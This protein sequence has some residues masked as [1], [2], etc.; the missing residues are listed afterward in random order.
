MATSTIHVNLI[1]NSGESDVLN[2]CDKRR[3]LKK[4]KNDTEGA[5]Q[6]KA[7]NQE[8]KKS[9]K[10]AKE[11]WIKEQC[12]DINDS[13]ETNNSKKAYHL[14]KDLTSTK[15]GRTTTI[16]DKDK[17][18]LTK[19]QDILKRLKSQAEK[20]IAE[21]QAGFRQGRS[22]TEQIFNLKILCERY[23]QHQQD[24]YLV[25]VDFKKAFDRCRILQ[26][27]HW[28]LVQNH[29]WSETR[30]LLSPTLFNI[31]L[32]RI[33]TEALEDSEGTI[34]AE[35]TKLMTNNTNGSSTDIKV[36]GEKV[37]TVKSF[38]YLG[39]IVIDAGSKSEIFTRIAQTT[40]A[41]TK[42]KTILK[43]RNIALSSKIRL[44]R[45]LVMFRFL[46]A[47][48]AK[49]VLQGTVKGGRRRGR[50]RKRWEENVSEW[51]G[52]RLS[53]AFRQSERRDEWRELVARS[54]V[55]PNRSSRLRDK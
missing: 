16:P 43:D 38:K 3:D 48:L 10:K 50:K 15:Q 55:V 9:M 42:L 45:A 36:C 49:A 34:S 12:Q 35:K 22:T 27:Q 8:I 23:L 21:E 54:S 19:E 1:T 24:L 51:T 5:N 14:V 39:A 33:V 40:A 37:E 52:M 11:N 17:K 44:M 46:Y 4:K 2:L 18:C 7:V 53:E 47:W 26:Q 30:L 6:Y 25:F 41:H 20:I 31:F 28:G 32:D 29:S 13:L